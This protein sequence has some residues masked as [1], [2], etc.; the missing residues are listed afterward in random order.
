MNFDFIKDAEP[1]TEELKQLYNSLYA[2]LEEA[3]QVYWEKPQKCGMMLRRATEKMK[4][5]R[6]KIFI[7]GL[8]RFLQLR[9]VQ[10][11]GFGVMVLK[12]MIQ[13]RIQK[14]LENI[15]FINIIIKMGD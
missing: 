5:N 8:R 12:Q 3:E 4:R 11:T 7:K 15:L 6:G 14:H 13:N 1:S 9:I 2:N 10:Q